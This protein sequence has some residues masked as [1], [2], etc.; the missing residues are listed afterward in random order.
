MRAGPRVRNP[1][2]FGVFANRLIATGLVATGGLGCAGGRAGERPVR[3]YA[4]ALGGRLA[5][6][7]TVRLPAAARAADERRRSGGAAQPGRG[8]GAPAQRP[9][10][11]APVPQPAARTEPP[12][13][14]GGLRVPLPG[15][16]RPR[17][18]RPSRRCGAAPAAL[19]A[20]SAAG[21]GAGRDGDAAPLRC[22]RPRGR[23]QRAGCAARARR[24][25][26]AGGQRARP[27]S[28][29]V[30]SAKRRPGRRAGRPRVRPAARYLHAGVAGGGRPQPA[31][32]RRRR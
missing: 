25:A 3:R 31:R 19:A 17:R 8:S 14:A 27:G 11:A 13:H 30:D 2:V 28:A 10:R 21:A 18:R 24:R 16:R 32:R 23:S 26:G 15:A 9:D 7:A 22:V 5:A 4:P 6:G 29:A 20:R 1:S 12:A